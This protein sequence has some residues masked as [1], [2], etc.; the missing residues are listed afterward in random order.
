MIN[1]KPQPEKMAM[2]ATNLE[3]D[4][5]IV[6]LDRRK[7]SKDNVGGSMTTQHAFWYETAGSNF[8]SD[9]HCLRRLNIHGLLS[10]TS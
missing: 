1:T 4:H 5:D 9:R 6:R 7:R 8:W 3:I 10:S 2:T